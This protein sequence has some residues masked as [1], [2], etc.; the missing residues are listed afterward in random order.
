MYRTAQG[1]CTCKSILGDMTRV[2]LESW[3]YVA[4]RH[5][6]KASHG[7]QQKVEPGGF[8]S[9]PDAVVGMD[10]FR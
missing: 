3:H 1:S 4:K 5:V 8:I 7:L 10:E 9:K 2:L 6:A